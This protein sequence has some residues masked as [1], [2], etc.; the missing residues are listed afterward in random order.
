VF[1][2]HGSNRP[3]NINFLGADLFS[4]LD[5]VCVVPVDVELTEPRFFMA[6]RKARDARM[7][8]CGSRQRT[9][10]RTRRTVPLA[11]SHL[12]APE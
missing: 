6:S 3:Y 9:S 2:S 5:H 8:T 11:A 12:A 10:P 7:A 4:W 1:P